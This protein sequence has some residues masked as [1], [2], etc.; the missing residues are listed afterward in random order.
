MKT[1]WML[2]L[3]VLSVFSASAASFFEDSFES[4]SGAL[5]NRRP[6][7]FDAE[8]SAITWWKN[9]AANL[10]VTNGVL[11]TASS[12]GQQSAWM[13]LPNDIETGDVIRVSAV[14]VANGDANTDWLSIGLLQSK[15]HTFQRGDPY[16]ALTRR[17]DAGVN[18]GL[19]TVYGG[20]GD[21]YGSLTN[22]N[23]LK[24]AQGFAT[25]L[26][27]RNTVGF[28][29]DTATGNLR[30]W[31][32][33]EEGTTEIHY[34]GPVNYEGVANQAIP[35][36]DLQYVGVTFNGL[37]SLADSNPAYL[38]DLFVERIPQECLYEDDFSSSSGSLHNRRPDYFDTDYA[39]ISWWK[40]EALSFQVTNGVLQT[41]VS[42]GL[43]SAWLTL[44]PVNSG[45]VIR[46]SAVMVAN[47][48][49]NADHMGMGLLQSKNHLYQR[50]EPWVALTRRTVDPG[51]N[52]GLL[53]VYGGLGDD[54]SSLAFLNY[55]KEPQGFTT[56][57]NARNTV[58]FE[59]D[60]ASGNLQVWLTSEGGTTVT[61]YN[62][63]VN[64]GGVEGQ[65]VPLDELNY[66]GFTFKSLTAQGES[67][68]AYIDNL[69][70][71][72]I[73]KITSGEDPIIPA[74]IVG[75]SLES[76]SLMRM[77][78][79]AQS[80]ANNYQ[81]KSTTNLVSGIWENIAHSDNGMNAFVV[82]NLDYAG[83][84]GTNKVIF[85]QTDESVRFF[86]IDN[87]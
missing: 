47:G 40:N 4:N 18:T 38:D 69:S 24:E 15:N 45:D 23:Y 84:E 36:D 19:L 10:A 68:P 78:I 62:G 65:A 32:T 29:Y 73:P 2:C 52:M 59:Y 63:S 50:G 75:W 49:S 25:N 43:V 37:N 42:D 39:A 33:S 64:Y 61:Q 34:Y 87:P 3:S 60:T 6:D 14:L 8:Y 9:E 20:L 70:I 35:L 31:M 30:V 54:Y 76:G 83:T 55:L 71:V 66:F 67:N 41:T 82:T 5:H 85:L 53:Q 86:K 28:E 77:V 72:Y 44:P 22:A 79:D 21:D 56:N 7:S 57:L 12:T 58:G 80:A 46:A 17:E 11:Q 74:G 16:V 81:P 51:A 27:A 13:A 48:D 26:N 1:V